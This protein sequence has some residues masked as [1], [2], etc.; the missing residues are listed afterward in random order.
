MSVATVGPLSLQAKGNSAYAA[1]NYEEAVKYFTDA[2]N[3]DSKNHILYSNR[4][5]A[6]VFLAAPKFDDPLAP[7]YSAVYNCGE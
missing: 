7:P 6:L 4:S 2:V 5:A 3:S 1:G